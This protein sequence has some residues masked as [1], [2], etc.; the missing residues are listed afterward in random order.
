MRTS[1]I[2]TTYNRP[3][4]LIKVL[5]SVKIQTRFP[6]ELIIA[7]D[8]SGTETSKAIVEALSGAPF[9]YEHVWQEDLGFRAA[10]IRNQAIKKS[11]GDY[12]ILLD[13]DCIIPKKFIMDHIQLANEGFF[14]QGKRIVITQAFTPYFNCD[15]ANAVSKLIPLFFSKKI[16]NA[17][18]LIRIPWFPGITSRDLK[19]IKTC[20]MGFFKKDM[21]AVNGFNEDF[22]GWGREDSELAIRFFHYGLKRKSHP[23]M[24]VCFHLWH[25]E[26]NRNML[27][28][29]DDLLER[30]KA[31][32]E[33]FCTNGLEK[34]EKQYY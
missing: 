24:A 27:Q 31:S 17:H 14:F 5:E 20:N 28:V 26:Q 23:F 16:S 11:T 15:H 34:S 9:P 21:V 19:G 29:N 6:D 2:I 33:Y 4:A 12:I 10:R 30:S 3:D 13:G 25:C 1:L 32:N 22:I 7:D 8:G 18:H